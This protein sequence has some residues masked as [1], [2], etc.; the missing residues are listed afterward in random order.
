MGTILKVDDINVYYGSIHAIKGI[1]FEVEE[2]EVVTLIGANGA[3]KSTTLNTISGLLRSKTGSIEFMG[4]SLAK[5]PSHKIVERGLALVPEG[6]RIF[7]QMTVQENLE[8]G[9]FTQKGGETQQDLEKIYALF[10]RL[11]ERLK[12]MAGT[13][14]GGEQQML[15]MGRALMSKP[16]IVLMDEPS[17]GLSPIFVEEIFNII[18]E[19]SAEGT[20]VL[21]VEQNAKKALSIADRAY[22]L[23][24]GKIVLEGDAK[25][26]LNDE[27]IKKAYLGE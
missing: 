15:A 22:V 13:L 18:K 24:T 23:E 7:L 26:L 14:S 10:P 5:V 9:A 25:D 6:R 27:S 1:S 2:G 16:R 8:M 17:M 11:K 19:I 3:G 4:Q 21:L 12:Q 20:T